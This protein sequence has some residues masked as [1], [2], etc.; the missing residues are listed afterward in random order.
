MAGFAPLLVAGRRWRTTFPILAPSVAPSA[1]GISLRVTTKW[2]QASRRGRCGQAFDRNHDGRL[3]PG[4]QQAL[5]EHLRAPRHSGRGYRGR[6][7]RWS[8]SASRCAPRRP[9]IQLFLHGA[10]GGP[11]ELRA[12]WPSGSGD[13]LG[14]RR[15]S[16]KDED[17]SGGVAVSWR[18]ADLDASSGAGKKPLATSECWARTLPWSC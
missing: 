1:A 2:A 4:E 15:V 9:I 7:G 11:D 8:C 14:R 13:W 10:A 17:P 3:D 5:T 12:S 16:V 18:D 6:A